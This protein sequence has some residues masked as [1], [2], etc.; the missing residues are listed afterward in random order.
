M[1]DNILPGM[2][3]YGASLDR[4]LQVLSRLAERAPV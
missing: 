1:E 2:F 3:E 4:A